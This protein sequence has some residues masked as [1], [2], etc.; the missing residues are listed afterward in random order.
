MAELACAL[1]SEHIGELVVRSVYVATTTT[2]Q[3]RNLVR[4]STTRHW[5]LITFVARVVGAVAIVR[6]CSYIN[7]IAVDGRG[8][9][10]MV[11]N[12]VEFRG[13]ARI[14]LVRAILL[15]RLPLASA[16][17]HDSDRNSDKHHSCHC[18]HPS[19][20]ASTTALATGR[21]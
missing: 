5:N 9:A 15:G 3:S 1:G 20:S 8:G 11:K 19:Q 17:K 14:L 12:G 18:C 13:G 21:C 7:R 6:R 16:M 4:V 2:D 10:R